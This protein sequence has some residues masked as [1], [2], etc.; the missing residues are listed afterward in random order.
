MHREHQSDEDALIFRRRTYPGSL[1]KPPTC[2]TDVF[3]LA[4][5]ISS[6][7]GP[8]KFFNS[9]IWFVYAHPL[10]VLCAPSVRALCGVAL[11]HFFFAIVVSNSQGK[12]LNREKL[13]LFL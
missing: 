2:P 9:V 11:S 8:F 12:K 3:L 13:R 7:V 10:C 1:R 4:E 5:N 6:G